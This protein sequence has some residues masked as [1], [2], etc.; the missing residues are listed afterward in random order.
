MNIGPYT[1]FQK[2]LILSLI[3]LISMMISWFIFANYLVDYFLNQSDISILKHHQSLNPEERN[4][5]YYKKMVESGLL[6]FSFFWSFVIVLILCFGDKFK[7]LSDSFINENHNPYALSLFRII[8]FSA[9]LVYTEYPV[10]YEM[11][12]LPGQLIHSPIGW[13]GILSFL[14]PDQNSLHY[15]IPLFKLSLLLSI[16]GFRLRFFGI[17]S[18]ILG[19]WILGIPQFYGKINHYHHLLWFAAIAVF[20][21]SNEVWTVQKNKRKIYN[22]KTH[23]YFLQLILFSLYVMYFFPGA[24]KVIGSGFD[25]LWGEAAKRQIELQC[26]SLNKSLPVFIVENPLVY[27]FIGLIT[28]IIE[29][30]WGYWMLKKNTRIGMIIVTCIFHLSIYFIMDINFWI[31]PI[32]LLVFLPFDKLFHSHKKSETVSANNLLATDTTPSTFWSKWYLGTIIVFGFFHIDTWPFAVY[33][34]FGNPIENYSWQVSLR[35]EQSGKTQNVNL[36]GDSTL[37]QWL[38]KTR[39]LGLQKQIIGEDEASQLKLKSIDP[40]YCKALGIGKEVNRVYLKYKFNV[41]TGSKIDSLVLMKL[42]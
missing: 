3:V 41:A 39:L 24:W 2:V 11:S 37:R 31:L 1:K 25:W 4:F 16:L 33:P 12:G 19:I 22:S 6:R 30:T 23:R 35:F 32:F 14:K 5:D 27:K 38:P 40:F 26:I 15:L 42:P 36:V 29:L 17:V 20:A 18:V 8:S 21:P 13:S 9:L 34:S 10:I 28:I 7:K